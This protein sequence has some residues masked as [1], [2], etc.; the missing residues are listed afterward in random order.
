MS[1]FDLVIGRTYDRRRS[2]LCLGYLHTLGLVRKGLIGNFTGPNAAWATAHKEIDSI[3][4]LNLATVCIFINFAAEVLERSE[5]D[6]MEDP[7]FGNLPWW[8]DLLWAPVEFSPP[9]A[10]PD[11]SDGPFFFGSIP[12]LLSALEIIKSK[13]PLPLGTVPPSYELMR[14]DPKSF[15]QNFKGLEDNNECIQWIWRGLFDAATLA[16][17]HHQPLLGNG[18]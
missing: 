15:A 9:K 12:G 11:D 7:I 13:S 17:E 4:L 6:L 1:E 18:L 2:A 3:S 5:N 16:L 8:M 14:R 10:F